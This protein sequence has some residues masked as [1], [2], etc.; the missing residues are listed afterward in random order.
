MTSSICRNI[1]LKTVIRGGY[2]L[3]SSMVA[4]QSAYAANCSELPT[5]EERYYIV[6]ESSGKILDVSG[7]S[8]EDGA[9]VHQWDNLS[10]YNQQW[11]VTDLGNAIWSIRPSHSKK[12]LDVSGWSK[13]DGT[14]IHQWSYTGYVNQQW[15]I[16]DAGSSFKIASAFSNLLITVDGT[17]NGSGI[18]QSAGKSSSTQRWYINPVNGE[19][20]STT[21]TDTGTNIDTVTDTN[22]SSPGHIHGQIHRDDR[23]QN[24]YRGDGHFRP[25][26]HALPVNSQSNSAL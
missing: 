3:L 18:Y 8:S 9:K 16:H 19:C 21:G 7:Y 25:I 13:D 2:L 5:S 26:R 4:T 23:F 1:Q 22:S 20:G 14:A 12:S 17:E 24:G 6:N 11:D 15:K 10:S